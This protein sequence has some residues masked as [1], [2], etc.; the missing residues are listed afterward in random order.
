MGSVGSLSRAVLQPRTTAIK[1]IDNNFLQAQAV[2]IAEALTDPAK[3]AQLKALKELKSSTER[4]VIAAT[5]IGLSILPRDAVGKLIFPEGT[6]L[7]PILEN[8]D[9]E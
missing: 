5:I 6:V 3:V 8:E 1:A 7:P 4:S 9:D 2:R